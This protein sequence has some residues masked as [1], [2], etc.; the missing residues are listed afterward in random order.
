MGKADPQQLLTLMFGMGMDNATAERALAIAYAE[1]SLVASQVTREPDGTTSYGLMQINSVH[2]RPGG[3][4]ASYS[5]SSL[6]DPQRN[7]EAARTVSNGWHNWKPWTTF[8]TGSYTMYIPTAKAA[9]NKWRGSR[10][11]TDVARDFVSG[12]PGIDTATETVKTADKAINILTQA[13]TWVR[14]AYGVIGAGLILVAIGAIVGKR[15]TNLVIKQVTS[16]SSKQHPS[17]QQPPKKDSNESE[18]TSDDQNA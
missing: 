15:T 12:L 17:K 16:T 11:M 14:V 3:Q 18:G 6:L 2:L 7:L 5:P 8:K 1:S 13:G 9:V 10:G 4:L